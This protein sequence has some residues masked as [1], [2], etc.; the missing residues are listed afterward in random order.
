ML[1]QELFQKAYP[2]QWTTRSDTSY[3]A[4]FPVHDGRIVAEVLSI[5]GERGTPD[6]I[7]EYSFEYVPDKGE[8]TTTK[9]GLG[10]EF[11][12]WATV[13]DILRKFMI[14][15]NPHAVTLSSLKREP[16]RVRLFD[17]LWKKAF[18]AEWNIDRK[19]RGAA[20]EYTFT[21]K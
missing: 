14:E 8:S 4:E 3:E 2:W 11:M 18:G 19:E 7:W 12:I 13:V 9:T 15:V 16:T 10:D 5:G 6:E 17:R 21:K 20:V 1:L